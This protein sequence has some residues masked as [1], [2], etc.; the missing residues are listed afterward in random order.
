[1]ITTTTVTTSVSPLALDLD[2]TGRTQSLAM[3][4]DA[5]GLMKL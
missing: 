2:Q 3:M 1:V 4:I 5:M